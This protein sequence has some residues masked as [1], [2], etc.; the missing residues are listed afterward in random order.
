MV[1]FPNLNESL[2]CFTEDLNYLCNYAFGISKEDLKTTLTRGIRVVATTGV[3]FTVL[4]LAS[5]IFS[6]Q[7]GFFQ[8]L[9]AAAKGLCFHDWV[10]ISNNILNAKGGESGGNATAITANTVLEPMW[11]NFF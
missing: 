6:K 2:N 8:L 3:V 7:Y 1:S 4:Q 11:S 9:F 10:V 5:E